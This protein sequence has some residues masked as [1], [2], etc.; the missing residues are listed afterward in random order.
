MNIFQMLLVKNL[1][2]FFKAITN[3]ESRQIRA[4]YLSTDLNYKVDNELINKW[5]TPI[6]ERKKNG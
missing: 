5:T 3:K 6:W 1:L 4:E 2:H